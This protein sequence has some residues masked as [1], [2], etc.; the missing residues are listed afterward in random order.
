MVMAATATSTVSASDSGP[1]VD[2]LE[3]VRDLLGS[4]T[5]VAPV[6][7]DADTAVQLVEDG[8]VVDIPADPSDGI[9]IDS[10]TGTAV[11]VTPLDTQLAEFEADATTAIADGDGYSAV[12]QPLED[13]DFRLAVVLEDESAP[14]TL[15]YDF[16]LDPGVQP[17]RRED[18]G[19]DFV[20]TT[21]EV[22]GGIGS[23]WAIDAAG[24]PVAASYD[25]DGTVLTRTMTIGDSTV[26]PVLTNWCVFGKNP[27]GSCRG[28]GVVKNVAKAAGW[29]M[30]STTFC[31]AV[32]GA[33]TGPGAAVAG[34]ACQV[35][36]G[37]LAASLG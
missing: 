27:N 6:D 29:G 9:S 22:V 35:G 24:N 26:F 4:Q 20:N 33:A 28:S 21:G 36:I 18:G 17:V 3:V 19:Y 30:L 8:V 10:Q 1:G 34:A 32:A 15:S 25:F 14:T 7:H 16:E 12:A 31:Y 23:P 2:G 37:F 5:A 11:V 13:G